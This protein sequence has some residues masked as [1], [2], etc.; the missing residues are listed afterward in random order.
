MSEILQRLENEILMYDG[1]MGTLLQESGLLL[2]GMAPEELNITKPDE[3]CA[4]HKLYVDAGANFLET[5]TFGGLKKKLVQFGLDSKFKDL[6][7]AA[8]KNIRKAIGDADAYCVAGMG[9]YE[10]MVEPLGPVTFD[11][12]VSFY[13]EWAEVMANAGADMILFETFSDLKELKAA[14]IGAREVCDLPI[15]V[16]LTY[17][18]G[19]RTVTGTPADVAAVAL[20]AMDVQIIGTNC[21]SG[22]KEMLPVVRKLAEY[23]DKFIVAQPNAGMPQLVDGKTVFL[24]TPDDM[25]AYAKKFVDAGV[26]ILGGCCGSTPAHIAAMR[27]AVKDLKPKKRTVK[28]GFILTSRTKMFEYSDAERPFVIGERINPTGKKALQKELADEKTTICRRFAMEQAK[29]GADLLDINVGAP[30]T[31]EKKMMRSVVSAVQ[32]VSDLPLVIDSVDPAVIEEGLK[33]CCGKPLI[34]SANAETKSWKNILPLA[35]KYGAAIIGLTADDD[36]LAKTEEKRFEIA[37]FIKD[38]ALEF[39]IP[40]KD[41]VIDALALTISVEKEQAYNSLN[42]IK[43]IKE[44]LGLLTSLGVSNISFGL[45][46]RRIINSHYLALAAGFGLDFGILNPNV[47]EMMEVVT[48]KKK[49][50][51]TQ[52]EIKR[53]IDDSY[54]LQYKDVPAPKKREKT[55]VSEA[56]IEDL[57]REAVLMGD[58]ENILELV[59]VGLKKGIKPLDINLKILIPAIEEVGRKFEAKEYFL[60]QIIMSAETMQIASGRLNQELDADEQ[61][62]KGRVVFATVEGDIHDIGKNIVIAVLESYGYKVY[63]LGKDVKKDTIVK[64]ALDKKADIVGLSALMTTTM[65]AMEPVIEELSSRDKHIKVMVGGA[66][67]TKEYAESIGATGF[68]RDAIEAVQLANK[69]VDKDKRN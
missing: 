61:N 52:D 28:D 32:T 19:V 3:V 48:E 49:F 14:I 35:K 60:P 29:H 5:N 55:E 15:Q 47:E 22:P 17:G 41:I 66:A 18:D 2:P 65:V 54:A 24:E 36:G 26:S 16:Q 40:Q 62:V 33:E 34:N 51:A 38:K 4:V 8:V 59:E 64:E 53:F 23:S 57:L 1:A 50:E 63:D 7:A 9:P 58:K 43:R 68:S 45:P 13:R 6:N 20:S 30:N 39:G 11:E 37:K 69:I 21:S 25:A 10:R 44:E 67:V 46:H 27:N 56:N 12:A 31:D 42:A